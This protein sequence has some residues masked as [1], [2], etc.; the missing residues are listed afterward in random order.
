MRTILICLNVLLRN[1]LLLCDLLLEMLFPLLQ[2]VKLPSERQDGLLGRLFA[3]LRRR[4][5]K[6]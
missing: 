4:A 3:L 5:A 2:H 6:P 1:I